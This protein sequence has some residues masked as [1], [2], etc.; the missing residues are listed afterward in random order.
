MGGNGSYY[1]NFLNRK[2][3]DVVY[4]FKEENRNKHIL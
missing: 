2:S 4:W 1:L 3:M